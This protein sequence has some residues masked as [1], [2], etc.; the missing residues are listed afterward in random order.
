VPVGHRRIPS[1][2]G[3]VVGVMGHGARVPTRQRSQTSPS[4]FGARVSTS[5]ASGV[6]DSH[7]VRDRKS[8]DLALPG[9]TSRQA[10][11][12]H[13]V[14]HADA[15]PPT[16]TQRALPGLLARAWSLRI[17]LAVRNVPLRHRLVDPF[18]GL[19]IWTLR[20]CTIHLIRFLARHVDGVPTSTRID[21]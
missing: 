8:D 19:S 21:T 14:D 1:R 10:R 9:G 4:M 2:I 11:R 13:C 16:G 12:R 17:S 15:G 6:G 20:S 5:F 3:C 7:T 18:L